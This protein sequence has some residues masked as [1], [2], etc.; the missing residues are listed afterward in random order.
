MTAPC[1]HCCWQKCIKDILS[2]RV[3]YLLL[4]S[5]EK[6]GFNDW[7][8]LT[9]DRA[10]DHDAHEDTEAPAEVDGEHVPVLFVTD[11]YLHFK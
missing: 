2:S 8:D 4:K 1:T 9:W 7:L 10:G 11:E 3:F 5:L 6:K